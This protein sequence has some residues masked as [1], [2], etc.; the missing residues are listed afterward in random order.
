MHPRRTTLL[1]LA[2]L[3]TSGCVAVPA[4][5]ASAPARPAQ[6]Q[7]ADALPP[8]PVTTWPELTL[9]PPREDLS[10]TGPRRTT[11]ARTKAPALADRPATAPRAA[12]PATVR[13]PRQT[14]PKH[15]AT[16]A[17]TPIRS[18]A[19]RPKPRRTPMKPS[20]RR[21]QPTTGAAPDMRRLCR[22]AQGIQAPMG[23]PALCRRM[24]GR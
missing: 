2:A 16:K 21:Q 24:Y 19:A 13:P 15:P 22:Q 7:P 8:T 14:A 17:R 12:R 4:P 9:A 20:A 18:S 11:T 1:V 10:T 23:A 3:L 5:H 6:L